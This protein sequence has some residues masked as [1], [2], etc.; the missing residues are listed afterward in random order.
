MLV[1]SGSHSD[2]FESCTKKFYAYFQ[3]NP[4][5]V[6]PA[7]SSWFYSEVHLRVAGMM[8]AAATGT[9]IDAVVQ[10]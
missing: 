1:V 5:E 3:K 8:V 9:T 7:G 10:R 4:S 2:D 6:V